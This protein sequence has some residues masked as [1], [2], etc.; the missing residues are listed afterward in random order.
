MRLKVSDDLLGR[1]TRCSHHF[2]CLTTGKCGELTLCAIQRRFDDN[3][4]YVKTTEDKKAASCP[5]KIDFG[6]MLE[7]MCTCPI[8]YEHY[9]QTIARQSDTI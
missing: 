9:L 1:T 6:S 5:Y 3:M 2:S 7:H 4:L 8:H